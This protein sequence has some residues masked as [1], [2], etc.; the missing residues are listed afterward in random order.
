MGQPQIVI[1]PGYNFWVVYKRSVYGTKVRNLE[2]SH[3]G[4]LACLMGENMNNPSHRLLVAEN[5]EKAN[6]LT[7]RTTYLG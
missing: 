1:Y 7:P 5:R 2:T 3:A 4:I 6:A